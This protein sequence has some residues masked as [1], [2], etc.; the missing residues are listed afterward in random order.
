MTSGNGFREAAQAGERAALRWLRPGLVAALFAVIGAAGSLITVSFTAQDFL[1]ERFVLR[2]LND[3][4]IRSSDFQRMKD[5]M[6]GDVGEIKREV[7]EIQRGL[8]EVRLNQLRDQLYQL[9]RDID[10]HDNL[11]LRDE[12]YLR[13]LRLRCRDLEIK[14][15]AVASPVCDPEHGP[16]P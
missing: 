10:S 4:V 15:D 8:Q 13:A 3:P 6:A 2:R 5:S 14:L 1:E 7:S 9:E 12:Q 11:T 16:R